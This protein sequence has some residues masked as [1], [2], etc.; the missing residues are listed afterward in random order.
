MIREYQ[1]TEEKA[2][3][4]PKSG[5]YVTGSWSG[6]RMLEWKLRQMSK[7]ERDSKTGALGD[8]IKRLEEKNADS[9]RRS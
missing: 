8:A 7:E 9:I 1:L 2:K 4:W 6:D 3:R 5:C